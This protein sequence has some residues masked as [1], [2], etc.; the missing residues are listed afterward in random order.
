MSNIDLEDL[1]NKY[2]AGTC[3][4]EELA[5]LENWYAQW[6]VEHQPLTYDELAN[7]KGEVWKAMAND[8]K[9][10][11]QVRLWPRMAIAAA[12][13]AAI[14]VG[15]WVYVNEIASSRNASRNDEVVTSMN[16]IKPGSVGA[17]LTLANG[18]T[19][20]LSSATN[21]ELAKEAGVTIKKT[22]DGQL[23]YEIIREYSDLNGTHELAKGSVAS[24]PRNDDNAPSLREGTTNRAP[25][26][27][28]GANQSHTSNTLTTAKGETYQVKLPDGTAVW[29]NAASSLT[30]STSLTARGLR[31]VRLSGEAYFQVAKDK[32]HPF[33]VESKGQQIEVL[34]THFNINAYADEDAVK[35]TLL[36]GSVKVS[37]VLSSRTMAKDLGATATGTTILKPGQQS[38]LKG[39]TIKV[40]LANLAEAMAWKNGK[41]IF[42]DEPL[43]SI[44]R[45]IAR[46][47]DVDIEYQGIDPKETFG[48]SIS[49]FENVSKVLKKLELTGGVQF[50]IE[51]RRIIVSQ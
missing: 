34:G 48:G 1:L 51:G 32:A 33:I 29:L 16:D 15:T 4:A 12:A 17:T 44:M 27:L 45:K 6:K 23:I 41:F 37:P 40:H 42:N 13:V 47:Y 10:V 5:L 39:E 22:A 18:K 2:R 7:I 9:P 36:E 43:E 35:T 25:G 8:V 19:I 11:K 49:R 26:E 30:Y 24:V 14:T 3:T 21:G 50:K 31:M 38:I 28:S 46:W 20:K